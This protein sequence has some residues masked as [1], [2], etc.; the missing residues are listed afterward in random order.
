MADKLT[1]RG[2]LGSTI[3][4]AGLS[5][6][7]VAA[8][9]IGTA[10]KAA[11][12][13]PEDTWDRGQV[14]HILPAAN[15]NRF[16]IKTSF[17]EELV[18]VPYLSIDGRT[19]AGT[20]TD[21]AGQFWSFDVLGLEAGTKYQLQIVSSGLEPLC[22]PWPL[23]TH[24]APEEKPE[25]LRILAYT[26]AGGSE[27]GA[28]PNGTPFFLP[29]KDKHALLAR[30]LSFEPDVCI[31]NGDH[32]YWDQKTVE[33]KPAVFREAAHEAR[34]RVGELDHGQPMLSPANEA[35]FKRICDEQIVALYGVSLRSTPS[36]FLTDDHDLFENDEAHDDL[37]TIP[38]NYWMLT[39]AR[40]T[41][42]LYYPEFLPD[43]TRP[44]WMP[45]SD[46]ADRPRGVSE[47][48]GTLRYGDLLEALL[49]DCKRNATIKGPVATMVPDEVEAWI[50]DRTASSP[51]QH[52][53]HCPSTPFGWT[54]GKWGEPYSDYR[55]ADGSIGTGKP[56]P[57]WPRGW[58]HQHQRL[59]EAMHA[60]KNRRSVLLQG[61]MHASGHGEIL[62][63]GD[64]DFSDSP[65]S[66]LLSGTLG[67]G[68]PGFPSVYRGTGAQVP[69]DLSVEEP[70]KPIEKNGFTIIDVTREQ[71]TF[72]FFAWRP[73][74]PA[75]GI[76]SM[77]P[78]Y[79]V[80][81]KQPG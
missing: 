65:I 75:E 58:W 59:L 38:P 79:T 25:R 36:Y 67:T 2:F 27:N 62:K 70:F 28:L 7:G 23:K 78:V 52:M 22:A 61:D 8:M 49:F 29:M 56:K 24:P 14:R 45:G 48:Y 76:A 57:Y 41:Q 55:Q 68:A 16:L 81:I 15:H 71:M 17:D 6:M 10:A 34:D 72:L 4:A 35:T 73:P 13:M 31:A 46:A 1:R 26:C 43:E 51:A 54:A 80:T 5:T 33:N 69:A 53:L 30:A 60:R 42:A 37:I 40:S 32:I 44:K 12:V 19:I 21:S 74:Q 66:A 64:L 50:K 63:S 77:E 11:A 39:A 20:R 18:E 3:P 9:G 47:V